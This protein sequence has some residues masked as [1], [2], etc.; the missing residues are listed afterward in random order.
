MKSADLVRDYPYVYHM[1][2]EGSWPSI[3]RHGLLSTEALLDLWEVEGEERRALMDCHR[4]NSVPIHH[5]EFGITTIRDQKPMGDSGLRRCLEDGLEPED[6]YRLLNERVFFWATWDRLETLLGAR[7]YRGARQTVLTVDTGE[8]L[9]RHAG[10]IELTT[11]NTG[12]TRPR[13]FPRGRYSFASL[14]DFNYAASRRK[15]GRSKAIAE[16]VVR[17][18]VPD[19]SDVVIRVE[20]CGGGLPSEVLYER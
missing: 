15:R 8:L 4:P 5:S 14:P 9:A 12:S 2:W 16:V 13:P 3:Q 17:A 7:A 6:W 10:R 1:A 18:G 19:V 11:M 20:H